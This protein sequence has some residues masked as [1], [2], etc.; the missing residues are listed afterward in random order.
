VS[1][2][3]EGGK[4]D[5]HFLHPVDGP[6]VPLLLNGDVRH[7]RGRRGSMPVLLT[8]RDPDDVTRPDHLDSTAPLLNPAGA[9]RHDQGLAQRV[10][11]RPSE[12]QAR[13]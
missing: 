13:T 10:R 9:S 5:T 11:A 7:A 4:K 1:A 8:R 3:V 6:A 12:R 2:D